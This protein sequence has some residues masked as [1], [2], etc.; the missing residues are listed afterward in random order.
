MMDLRKFCFILSGYSLQP[1]N[2]FAWDIKND[3]VLK[4]PESY[5]K[6]MAFKVIDIDNTGKPEHLQEV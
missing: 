6:L 1:R 2:I 4:S 5:A 3:T